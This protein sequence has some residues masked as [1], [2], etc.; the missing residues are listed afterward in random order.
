MTAVIKS[1]LHILRQSLVFTAVFSL[2]LQPIFYDQAL[3]NPSNIIP[4]G[5]TQTT[6]ELSPNNITVVNIATPTQSGT[7]MNNFNQ[8]NVDQTGAIIN[9]SSIVV[10]TGI[11]GWI[12]ANPYLTNGNQASIIVGEV[13]GNMPSNLLGYTEIAGGRAEFVLLN[14]NGISCAGCGFI[15]TNS[16]TLGTG[17]GMYNTDGS[18]ASIN[19][20]N[21][22]FSV[23]GNGLDATLVDYFRIISKNIQLS[24]PIWAKDE[25]AI[26]QGSSNFN[27]TTNTF[28][29]V[30]NPNSGQ[31]IGIDASALGSMYA[32]KTTLIAS[33]LGLGVNI[34]S[35]VIASKDGI[36]ITANGDIV[37]SNALLSAKGDI[38]I[39]S[40]QNT[41]ITGTNI[42]SQSGNININTQ[43]GTNTSNSAII[44]FRNTAINAS[45]IFNNNGYIFSF[46]NANLNNFS[47]HN[48]HLEANT[49]ILITNNNF[50]LNNSGGT[51]Q[52]NNGNTTINSNYQFD[53]TNGEINS[54]ND[55]NLNIASNQ[56]YTDT[57]SKINAEGDIYLNSAGYDIIEGS[58]VKFTTSNLFQVTSRDFTNNSDIKTGHIDFN[59]SNNLTNNA[60]L[61]S[62]SDSQYIIRKNIT[63]TGT[64]ASGA[65]L[66]LEGTNITNTNVGGSTGLI[67]SASNMEVAGSSSITNNAN[68]AIVS[69]G[70]L[71]IYADTLIT[72]NSYIG[73]TGNLTLGGYSN[74]SVTTFNN[75]SASVSAYLK[76]Q[77]NIQI[78]AN[79]INNIGK[80]D[81]ELTEGNAYTVATTSYEGYPGM[82]SSKMMSQ[83]IATN[84]LTSTNSQIVG[85][86]SI[87]I[88]GNAL[89]QTGDILAGTNLTV[90]GNITN[91]V[92]RF[93]TRPLSESWINTYEA[94]APDA[95]GVSFCSTK[96]DW[97]NG[98]HTNTFSSLTPSRISAGNDLIITGNQ[99]S[100][101][102]GTATFQ[103]NTPLGGS[104][105]GTNSGY[106]GSYASSFINSSN[107]NSDNIS[108]PNLNLNSLI[109]PALF[110]MNQNPPSLN[111]T[112]A[113]GQNINFTYLYESN[114]LFMTS[115]YFF[116]HLDYSPSRQIIMIGDPY[117]ERRIIEDTIAKTGMVQYLGNGAIDQLYAN[118]LRYLKNNQT[119]TGYE[120]TQTQIN[121]LTEDIMIP[122]RKEIKGKTVIVPQVYYSP[123][124]LAKAKEIDKAGGTITAGNSLTLT[125][126]GDL[127]NKGYLSSGNNINLISTSGNIVNMGGALTSRN[128]MVI[129]AAKNVFLDAFSVTNIITLPSLFGNRTLTLTD[130]VGS[131]QIQNATKVDAGGNL[132]INAANDFT[133]KGASI[134]SAG[135]I[136]ITAKN[137]VTL[138]AAYSNSSVN[139]E[140]IKGASSKSVNT[141]IQTGTIDTTQKLM[142]KAENDRKIQDA[143]VELIGFLKQRREVED[144]LNKSYSGKFIPIF[145]SVPEL[146]KKLSSLNLQIDNKQ[147]QIA[148]LKA[149]NQNLLVSIA[150]TA[151]EDVTIT[152][153]I[154]AGTDTETFH[155][156]SSDNDFFGSSTTTIDTQSQQVISS[157]IS[158][159]TSNQDINVPASI[160]TG[161]GDGN[162]SANNDINIQV[163]QNLYY[164]YYFYQETDMDLGASALQIVVAAL[165]VATAGAEDAVTGNSATAM[166]NTP[167]G[168]AMAVGT[169][170]GTSGERTKIQSGTQPQEAVH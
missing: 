131:S 64:I 169:Q 104:I 46:G 47:N 69:G 40:N 162:I 114:P 140:D 119:Q 52:S 145:V 168:A 51:I 6:T 103:N 67:Y 66:L 42:F 139:A 146:Q 165:R 74:T 1:I 128:G 5:T 12:Y 63:N 98:S 129:I 116:E 94:C 11:G 106:S 99:I 100:N 29:G 59:I 123:A 26:Y 138:A 37:Y 152:A 44:S 60:N 28:S 83:E 136:Q 20:G 130:A 73:S 30:A 76:S 32:G 156:H 110:N 34:A 134:K 164:N 54:A 144:L 142:Q 78:S 68:S 137:N 23:S 48:G 111:L 92:T 39:T 85:Y 49:S 93:T 125:S 89:N 19:M 27:T 141:I 22:N 96:H 86:G 147:K 31:T 133:A 154:K 61:I 80:D 17:F 41:N 132:T 16:L 108:S 36:T 148:D 57:N 113:N 90:N 117:T 53:N 97:W 95:L 18:L 13:T 149:E 55:I 115:N 2:V 7:S 35:D 167:I 77:G 101:D 10:N 84:T 157:L 109:N 122:V 153:N 170:Y 105:G 158:G 118:G 56:D 75:G 166:K 155:Y 4:D 72:N 79:Q 3:A 81:T 25:L 151:D 65:T 88:N 87:L 143:N 124:T 120:L 126:N 82:N 102:S 161:G 71:G 14:P 21:G 163:L 62:T 24:A 15:N 150:N 107:L 8:F 70:T 45:N 33:D 58:G 43:T 9:N 50:G 91:N 38:N 127:V 121:M 159:H 112:N 135:D 160:I